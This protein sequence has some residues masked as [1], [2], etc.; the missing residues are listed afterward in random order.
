MTHPLI[1]SFIKNGNG[2]YFN[3]DKAF[4]YQCVDVIDAYAEAIFPGKK[5][6][7]TIGPVPLGAR[8]LIETAPSAYWT[9]VWNNSVNVNQ[10]PPVGS[11]VVFNG[12][13]F[14]KYGH[15][16]V[17]KSRNKY[18]VTILQ[19]DGFRQVKAH[20]FTWGWHQAGTGPIRGWL[21]PREDKMPVVKKPSSTYTVKSGDT[22]TAIAAAKKTSVKKLVSLNKIKDADKIKVGQKLKVK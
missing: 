6:E 21:I 10:L 3:P 8:Q 5:W 15:T 13:G 16:G 19:Q 22:L 2:K 4:G 14:N 17:V 12:D 7:D 11:V 18:G 9:R 1:S 20:Y